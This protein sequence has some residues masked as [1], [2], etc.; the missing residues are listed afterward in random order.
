MRKPDRRQRIP[1]QTT[2]KF[3]KL[4]IRRGAR[5]DNSDD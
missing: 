3:G 1:D 4:A 5:L 2:A